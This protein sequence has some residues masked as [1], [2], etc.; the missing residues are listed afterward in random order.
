VSEQQQGQSE[1][2]G[3]E[4]QQAAGYV[5]PGSDQA[6][7]MELAAQVV[8]RNPELGTDRGRAEAALSTARSIALELS[9]GDEEYAA[10]LAADPRLWDLADAA[11]QRE[12]SRAAAQAGQQRAQPEDPGERFEREVIR[13]RQGR[14]VLPFGG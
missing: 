5:V 10:D 13:A 9:G 4:Q 6:W 3:G 2:Q 14:H 7:Q 11:N 8:A 1:P 12:A